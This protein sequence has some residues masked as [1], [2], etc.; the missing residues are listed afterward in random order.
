MTTIRI[1]NS[2]S[3]AT[4]TTLQNGELAYSHLSDNLFIGDGSTVKLVGGK[5][6]HDKLAGIEAGAQVNT[7]DSVAGKTGSVTLAKA[8]ITDFTEASY[9]H[10][11]GNETI[12]GVKTFSNNVILNGDLTVNGTTTTVNTTEVNVGDNIILLN[13]DEA[14]TPSQD[15]GIEIERGTSTNVQFI[16]NELVDKWGHKIVGGSFTA[17]SLEGHTH[18]SSDITDIVATID[19]QIGLSALNAL[20]DVVITSATN[21]QV[22]AFNGTNW[23][24]QAIAASTF[25]SLTDAPSSYSGSGSNIIAVNAGATGLEFVNTI[26]GGTF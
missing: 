17:M 20:G 12:S 5:S 9:V 7:V 19:G 11:T 15:S 10:A 25:L 23:I 24:N 14:G 8:D 6:D 1:K 21:G 26:D 16:W 13:T 3:T 4:P 18:P 2:G 22:L